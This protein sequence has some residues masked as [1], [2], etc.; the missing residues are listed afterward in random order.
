MFQ[1][2]IDCVHQ[3]LRQ[4]PNAFEFNEDFLICILRC[5]QS[6]LFGN[7]YA[8]CEKERIKFRHN[9]MSVWSIV[10]VH[11]DAFTNPLYVLRTQVCIPV[12]SAKNIVV[13]HRWFLSW[14][15]ATWKLLWSA[16]MEDLLAPDETLVD[17]IIIPKAWVD[18][19][20]VKVCSET[21]CNREFTIYRRRHHCRSCGLIF[22]ERCTEYRRIVRSV[23]LTVL[24][25]CCRSCAGQ[26][27]MTQRFQGKN[28]SEPEIPDS[29]SRVNL[30]KTLDN[31]SEI[32]GDSLNEKS[33]HSITGDI[34]GLT[35]GPK[36][37]VV[38]D[39]CVTESDYEPSSSSAVVKTRRNSAIMKSKIA[40]FEKNSLKETTAS[41]E[42]NSTE[43]VPKLKVPTSSPSVTNASEAPA[44]ASVVMDPRGVE[45]LV[46]GNTADLVR[47][48]NFLRES[49]SSF[50]DELEIH[51]STFI[52]DTMYER[53]ANG[54]KIHIRT[55]EG[56]AA[57]LSAIEFLRNQ[58]PVC[59][60]EGSP[61]LEKATTDHAVDLNSNQLAGHEGSDGSTVASRVE[62]YASWSGCMAEIIDIGFNKSAMDVVVSLVVC[63]GVPSRGYRTNILDPS[64]KFIGSSIGPHGDFGYFSV[65]KLA[66]DVKGLD[67]I[68]QEDVTI[69]TKDVQMPPDFEQILKSIPIPQVHGDVQ[70]E[71]A[72]GNMVEIEYSF[73]RKTA[74]VRF[75]SRVSKRV[76]KLKWGQAIPV[77]PL[78]SGLT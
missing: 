17:S 46:K 72:N 49:P 19:N 44:P 23:S 1:Q 27:D 41:D 71:L 26:I 48:I 50:V 11:R 4:T 39:S 12:A 43:L 25:R 45:S 33:V 68:F 51:M 55:N 16:Q 30:H 40:K 60:M 56:R 37:A 77:P 32:S 14:H 73:S 18:D 54:Q 29:S 74:E 22:C 59:C 42:V 9:T 7:I 3:I 20:A 53:T 38:S 63:D 62:R 61:F 21:S 13:W 78:S 6:G 65:I 31:I 10:F 57:V 52:D 24:S 69:S 28:K 58:E 35:E 15:D 76:M 2:F 47:V 8:N 75:I 64:F 5:V 34:A 70:R 67:T 36:S 66:G